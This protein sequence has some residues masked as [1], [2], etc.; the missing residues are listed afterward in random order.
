[1]DCPCRVVSTDA[2][3]MAVKQERNA[4]STGSKIASDDEDV[5]LD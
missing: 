5:E 3:A 1:M 4:S 2:H